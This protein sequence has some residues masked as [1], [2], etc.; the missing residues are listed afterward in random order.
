MF[1]IVLRN[2]QV[3]SVFD[4]KLSDTTKKRRIFIIS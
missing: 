4:I 3:N 2:P 1:D